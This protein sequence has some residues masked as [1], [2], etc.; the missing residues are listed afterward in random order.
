MSTFAVV[1]V[2]TPLGSKTRLSN[3]APQERRLLTLAMLQDVLIALKSSMIDETVVISPDVNLENL[4][5][6][7]DARFIKETQEGLNQAL[8]QATNWCLLK[9][10]ESVLIL[11]ADVPLLTTKDVNQMVELSLN[12]SIVISPS[13]NGGTNALLRS[14]PAII[15]TFFGPDSFKKH[16]SRAAA[17][18][19]RTKIF[20][21]SNIL[22]DIDSEKDV[23]RLQ[24]T[25]G[26]TISYRCLQD[27][28]PIK[29]E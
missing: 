19:L 12:D 29:K 24:A 5:G 4:V 3:F 26:Q 25:G 23:Y 27:I 21:S 1:P 13:R 8:S 22:L 9:G 7:F 14:P 6:D 11:P 15:P 10:A 17:K 20:V 28:A 2:K 18:R 16:I